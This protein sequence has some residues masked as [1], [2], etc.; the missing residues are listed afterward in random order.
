MGGPSYSS[1]KQER[2]CNHEKNKTKNPKKN[3][4]TFL[5]FSKLDR[6]CQGE[7]STLIL[8]LFSY[9]CYTIK[10]KSFHSFSLTSTGIYC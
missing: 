2:N 5:H 8:A 9:A 3:S 1:D 7:M 10:A 4:K 6:K